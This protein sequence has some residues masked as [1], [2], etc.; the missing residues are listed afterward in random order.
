MARLNRILALLAIVALLGALPVPALAQ[1]E[2]PHVLMGTATING[3]PASPGTEIVAMAGGREVGSATARAGGSFRLDLSNP[4]GQLVTFMISG[5][6]A[7]QTLDGWR[8]GF[9]Q[10]NYSLDVLTSGG[11]GGLDDG[12]PILP[13]PP[14]PPGPQGPPG[15]PGPQ[16]PPG[17]DGP[18]GEVGPPGEPGPPG[19]TGPAG[20]P[21]ERG[22]VGP[23]GEVG[24]TGPRGMDGA[25]GPPGPQGVQGPQGPAGATGADGS[26]NIGLIAIV[27]AV[28]A[29]IVAMAVPFLM[30]RR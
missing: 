17:P 1:G 25:Q 30:P 11:P 9:V 19:A 2:P 21:G 26:N 29:V 4:S 15:P 7:L 14:G 8:S 12:L 3:S 24:E 18:P 20:E 22:A 13:G 5:S 16:G 27:I 10:R 6:Q 23:Q 28:V